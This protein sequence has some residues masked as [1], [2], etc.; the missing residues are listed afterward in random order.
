M[1]YRRFKNLEIS[2]VSFGGWVL[3]GDLYKLR[4]DASVLVKKALDLGI[5]YF[6]VAD[7]Y[8]RGR[9]EEAIGELLKGYEA[10]VST[11]VGYDFYNYEP[12]R[13]RFDGEYLKFAYEMSLRR[14]RRR[15]DILYLHN[16]SVD[17][18]YSS[19]PLLR[20]FADVV[21]AALGPETDVLKE[22]VAALSAGYDA[23]MFVFNILEQ[24]PGVYFTSA[25]NKLLAVRVPHA[26][27]VLT[28]KPLRVYD[29]HRGLRRREWIVE[30][31]KIVEREIAPLA[32]ELGLTLGQYAVKFVLSYP[33][34][35]V[36]L[37]VTSVE[38]LEE[39]A[40][41]SDGKPLPKEHIDALR[42][43]WRRYRSVLKDAGGGI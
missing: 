12:P 28:N 41:A 16:P 2:E 37:T 6:D 19:L 42:E 22:G 11:K 34:T 15:P 21:G 43:F 25:L 1:R 32:K 29:D 31:R 4:D 36:L 8:G 3:S 38:E 13:R 5:N 10:Y 26:T 7:V 27:D 30:A 14:L 40:E 33:V 35:T 18:I 20:E 23:V 39:Y 17:A 24:E 9:A